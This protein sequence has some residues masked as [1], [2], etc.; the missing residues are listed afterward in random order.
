M[1][2]ITITSMNKLNLC[3]RYQNNSYLRQHFLWPLCTAENDIFDTF[4]YFFT[5]FIFKWF[6]LSIMYLSLLFLHVVL[7]LHSELITLFDNGL[8]PAAGSVYLRL[9]NADYNKSPCN[10]YIAR[11][12]NYTLHIESVE[13]LSWDG[14]NEWTPRGCFSHGGVSTDKI[15]CRYRLHNKCST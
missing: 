8:S 15:Y 4:I 3:K 6:I 12:V 13:C 2:M 10:K 14:V 7:N 11:A 9:L 1:I 5:Y